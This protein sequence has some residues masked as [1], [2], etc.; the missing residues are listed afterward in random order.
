MSAFVDLV[1]A[2]GYDAV[3]VEDVVAKGNVGR[4]TFYVHY[5]SKE[6]LL[7]ESLKRPSS[8]LAVIVGHTVAPTTLL[9]ILVHFQE[10]KKINRVFFF[11]PIRAIW[12]R[13]L[14]EMIEPRLAAICGNASGARP[15][16]PLGLIALQ[17]AE[18]QIALVANWLTGK[19]ACKSEA[20]AE[21]LI[22]TTHANMSA[23]LRWKFETPPVIPGERPCV[24]HL[25]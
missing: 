7:K 17:I 19:V 8:F 16:L 20:I 10:Q 21:A 14:A 5:K 13:A 2:R 23:L 25:A 11:P 3:T 15:A 12:V 6:H 4:S 24:E 1:L 22:A 9:P 18:A